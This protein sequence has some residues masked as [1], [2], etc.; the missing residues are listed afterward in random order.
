MGC[1][2]QRCFL[3]SAPG[4]HCQYFDNNVYS[5]T[6]R[7]W[8]SVLV[9]AA[10]KKHLRMGVIQCTCLYRCGRHPSLNGNPFYIKLGTKHLDHLDPA[11]QQ[12]VTNHSVRSVNPG[13]RQQVLLVSLL[14]AHKCRFELSRADD[15]TATNSVL[16]SAR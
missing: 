13:Q 9:Q 14:L 10:S 3:D 4:L 6:A 15:R 12:L 16:A 1:R 8:L 7:A 2:D 11:L 5:I